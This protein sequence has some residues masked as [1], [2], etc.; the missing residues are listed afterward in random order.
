MENDMSKIISNSL[1][2]K[3]DLLNEKLI[4]SIIEQ[5]Q[6]AINMN[7]DTLLQ[8][9][10]ID[11]KNDNARMLDFN[12]IDNIFKLVK[13]ENTIYGQVTLSQKDEEQKIIYGK[14]VMDAGNVV[15]INDGNIYVILEM[16]L[17]NLLAGN[18]TIFANTG[19]MY[20]T[21]QLLIQI[22]QTVFEQFNLS[23][24]FVQTFVDDNCED[25]LSNFANIDLVVCIGS[26][27]LQMSVAQKSRSKTILSGY[28]NFDLYIEDASN[29]EFLNKITGS[30]V[31]VQ[32][33]INSSAKLN[34]SKAI[35]VDDIDEA[36]AQINYNG[37]KY[38]AAIFT[39]STENASKF[40]KEVKSKRVSINASPTI[41]R[42]IDIKQSDLIIEKT[43]IYPMSFNF[44][45]SRQNVELNDI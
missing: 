34:H 14:E 18:T 6:K 45:G 10:M 9:N 5:I 16:L 12:I 38:S 42:L 37:S 19:Y 39:T 41:E 36:I 35:I 7:K 1:A 11:H 22:I 26:H 4:K 30:G 44:D 24:Y 2:V 27:S 13:E 25:I 15:V 32:L 17:R 3:K 23:K 33:Y 21:N 43:I 28:E 29:L 20:G 8:A 31:D 40:I